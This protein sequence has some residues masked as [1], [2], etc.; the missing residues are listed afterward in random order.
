M[1]QFFGEK[2]RLL[3]HIFFFQ[4]ESEFST[5]AIAADLKGEFVPPCGAC[6]QFLSEFNP[7]MVIYLVRVEDEQVC[8]TN[9]N[10]LMPESFSP[11]T[12]NMKSICK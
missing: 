8:Q 4:G 5:V 7:N 10:F 11:K 12:F 3:L 6:R 1:R 9:L 2:Y